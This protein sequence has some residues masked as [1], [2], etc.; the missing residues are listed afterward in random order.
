MATGSATTT[1]IR[2]AVTRQLSVDALQD[3][4]LV[5]ADGK[6]IGDIERVAENNADRKQFV[7]VARR[8]FLGFGAKEIAIPLE[9]VA[10]HG[11]GVTLQNMD[12]AQLDGM[13]EY[14]NENNAYRELDGTQQVG[15]AQQQ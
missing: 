14:R 12:V 8:G 13:A 4:D 6:K 5:G 10:V 11:T 7:V 9:N 3:F 2:N 1:T 15:L